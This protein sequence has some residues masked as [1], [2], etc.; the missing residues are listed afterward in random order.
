MVVAVYRNYVKHHWYCMKHADY[1]SSS[2]AWRCDKKCDRHFVLREL[3]L[4]VL[5]LLKECIQS[6]ILLSM[7]FSQPFVSRPSWHFIAFTACS[8]G[9]NLK[10]CIC[11]ITKLIGCG[12]SEDGCDDGVF[13]SLACCTGA[14]VSGA[15]SFLPW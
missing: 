14:V 12:V 2:G 1:R 13:K 11:F 7:L 4:S 8:I 9:A 15:F 5:E 10:L 3:V 6:G